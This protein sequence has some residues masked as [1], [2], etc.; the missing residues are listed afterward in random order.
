MGSV[1]RSSS[2]W[3]PSSSTRPCCL[4]V[5]DQALIAMLIETYLEDINCEAAGPFKSGAEALEWLK[6]HTPQAAILDYGLVDGA[7]TGLAHELLRRRIPFMVYSGYP[8]RDDAPPEFK[9]VPWIEKPCRAEDIITAVKLMMQP[10]H[11]TQRLSTETC[12]TLDLDEAR[13]VRGSN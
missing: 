2:Q 7:C 8:C 3:I 5:E 13:R 9:D 1:T 4:I 11:G 12:E 6:T 10:N